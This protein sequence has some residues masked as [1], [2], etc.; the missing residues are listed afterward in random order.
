MF[1]PSMKGR[2]QFIAIPMAL[3]LK[4]LLVGGTTAET[5]ESRRELVLDTQLGHAYLA[6]R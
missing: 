1:G 4:P 3:E 5:D 6:K 2:D